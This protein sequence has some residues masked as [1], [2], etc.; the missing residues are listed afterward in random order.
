VEC[1]V[2]N[3]IWET[4]GDPENNHTVLT[5][6]R[7]DRDDAYK[8]RIKDIDRAHLAP[9]EC[10]DSDRAIEM[11]RLLILSSHR[12]IKAQQAWEKTNRFDDEAMQER[13]ESYR[14]FRRNLNA[15]F[16]PKDRV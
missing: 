3:P 7:A 1:E 2:S 11:V 14:E 10:R 6:F 16:V 13:R 15:F 5:V 8:Y 9:D 12:F 4:V